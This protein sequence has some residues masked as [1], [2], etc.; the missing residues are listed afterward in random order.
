MT[1]G[2]FHENINIE[3]VRGYEVFVVFPEECCEELMRNKW[4]RTSL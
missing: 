4:T 1:C 3:F 2:G